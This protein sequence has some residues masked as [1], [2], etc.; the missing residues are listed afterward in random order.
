MN[1]N[2]TTPNDTVLQ[3]LEAIEQA[4]LETYRDAITFDLQSPTGIDPVASQDGEL[5]LLPVCEITIHP[6]TLVV[7]VRPA[8]DMDILG[9]VRPEQT[10]DASNFDHIRNHSAQWLAKGLEK[11]KTITFTGQSVKYY[12]GDAIEHPAWCDTAHRDLC[13]S[14]LAF[15]QVEHQSTTE[16]LATDSFAADAF[17]EV[18][19]DSYDWTSD[20]FR[21][22]RPQI[23]V[24]N[25]DTRDAKMLRGTPADLKEL[26]QFIIEQADRFETM[27]NEMAVSA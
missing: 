3:A 4:R 15:D 23:R 6:D 21:L 9:G 25:Q 7:E 24:V 27:I 8:S 18:F 20:V 12:A 22:E 11:P 5:D 13:W 19:T 1:S 10:L 17:L 14:G 26:G 2:K 16:K